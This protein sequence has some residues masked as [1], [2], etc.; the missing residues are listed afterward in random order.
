[1]NNQQALFSA[2]AEPAEIEIKR[3]RVGR[4]YRA[5]YGGVRAC[6]YKRMKVANVGE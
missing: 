2:F 1:M 5:E 6:I 4:V 3:I